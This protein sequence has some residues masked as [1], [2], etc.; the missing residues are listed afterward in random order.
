MT[1]VSTQPSPPVETDPAPT[2]AFFAVDGDRFVP[3]PAAQGPWGATVSGH[4][5]GGLLG[6][7]VDRAGAAPELQPARLTVDL[8]RPTFMAPLQV[9]ATVRREGKRIKVVDAELLQ[10]DVVSARASA[11]F[12]RR[13]PHPEGQVWSAPVTMPPI[14]EEPATPTADMPFLLWAYGADPGTGILGGTGEQWAQDP[15][16]KYAWVREL[17]PLIDGEALTPFDRVAL[18]GDVT[19]ALTHWGT[20]GLRYIN[21]DFTISLA[22]LPEGEHIGL[23]AHSHFGDA[24]VA[25]GSATLFDRRGPIGS[26][27][28]VALAQPAEAFRPPRLNS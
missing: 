13:G 7:A 17:R 16:P 18:A 12:L 6:W 21:A 8:L 9:R 27:I 4:I 25:S 26:A 10:D 11:V 20:D 19:S 3:R 2:D 1:G 14:P 24:G 5:L 28:A 15:G 22:R 23:A